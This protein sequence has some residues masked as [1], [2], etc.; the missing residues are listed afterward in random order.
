MTDQPFL[1]LGALYACASL[2]CF[3]AYGLDKSAARAGRRRTPER[4]L[5]LLG[6][7]GGWPGGVLAQQCFRHKTSKHSFQIKFWLAVAIN[8]GALAWLSSGWKIMD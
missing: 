7:I 1:M 6:L 2:V 3:A 4:T 8:L 5:L